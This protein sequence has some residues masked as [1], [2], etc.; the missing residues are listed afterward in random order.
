MATKIEFFCYFQNTAMKTNRLIAKD[1]AH[2]KKFLA[3]TIEKS[4]Y[5]L[6]QITFHQQKQ[7]MIKNGALSHQSNGFFHVIGVKNRNTQEE[8]LALYQPQS[9]LTGLILHKDAN[10][11]VYVLLQ[12]RVEPGNTNIGQYGPTIQSTPA[13]YMQMHGGKKTSYVDLFT[14]VFPDVT[15]LGSTMQFDIG[16]CYFQKSKFHNYL[17][18]SKFLKTEE[19]MI[20]VPLHVIIQTLHLDN[21][22]NADLRSLL[23]V[24]DWDLY[25]K[26]LNEVQKTPLKTDKFCYNNLLGSD[27]W[28]IISLEQL[29]NW[30]ISDSGI[31]NISNSSISIKMFEFSTTNREVAKWSQPLLCTKNRG[32]VV[33]LMRQIANDYEFLVSITSE[34]GISGQIAV[35]PTLT[36]YPGEN[37][38]NIT[39]IPYQ[40]KL[41]AEVIQSDE[42]GRFYR[43]ESL[44]QVILIDDEINIASNQH[45]INIDSFKS[46][47]KSSDTASIQLRTLASLVLDSINTKI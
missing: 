39:T 27:K 1:V 37:N 7:W 6:Q 11:Q 25:L 14:T 42:G 22:L 2:L 29:K 5:T 15:P 32:Y 47:L 18:V 38:E 8:Q 13:N 30:N 23:A 17:G 31:V 35:L 3:A 44:Y 46:I 10:N 33:L 21:F 36:I 4:Q 16:K 40:G 20:W 24:F 34:F 28:N 26:P 9:A 43:N 45:W 19:N 12:A 41:L